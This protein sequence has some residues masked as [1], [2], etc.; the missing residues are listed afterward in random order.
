MPIWDSVV[1]RQQEWTL[2]GFR[3]APPYRLKDWRTME[4]IVDSISDGSDHSDVPW[5]LESH[6]SGIVIP[7]AA[8][9]SFKGHRQ[10]RIRVWG[11]N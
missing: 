4:A 1:G 6:G 5:V 7:R 8:D 2:S 9:S 11:S 3:L 10:R